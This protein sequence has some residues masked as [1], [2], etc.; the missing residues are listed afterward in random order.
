MNYYLQGSNIKVS[1]HHKPLAKFLNR[2]NANN[3]VNRWGLELA[4]YKITFEWIPGAGSK[5]ADCLSRLVKLPNNM[6]ATVRMLT[7]TNLDEQAFIARSQTSQ[8]C[9]TPQYT[10]PSHTP[11][12]STPAK[13]NL[14]TVEAT[15]DI[16]PKPLTADRQ[17]GLLQMQRM[18]PFCKCISRRLSNGKSPQHEADLFT[19]IKTLLYKHVTDANCWPSSYPKLENKLH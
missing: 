1:N 9:Q 7:A 3:K 4:M 8:H 18:N 2:K 12:I 19:H 11:S 6:K 17:E 5:A 14:T 10:G 16:T 13:S 15:Q